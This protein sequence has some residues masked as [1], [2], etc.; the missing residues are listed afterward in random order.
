MQVSQQHHTIE[1]QPGSWHFLFSKFL[2]GFSSPAAQ[3]VTSSP[4]HPTSGERMNLLAILRNSSATFTC[5]RN[6]TQN[7]GQWCSHSHEM[8][9]MLHM[10][11]PFSTSLAIFNPIPFCQLHHISTVH[12]EFHG[13][14]NLNIFLLKLC[15][16]SLQLNNGFLHICLVVSTTTR[17]NTMQ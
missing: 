5:T 13:N 11:V 2:H 15:H 6:H 7:H 9:H 8:V 16:L 4:H 1:N 14:G 10:G 17:Y 3:H 12:K